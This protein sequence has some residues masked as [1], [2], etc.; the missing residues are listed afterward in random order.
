MT[1]EALDL[2]QRAQRA[3]QT[4]QAIALQDPDA[5]AS[6]SY[7]A[8]F[9][10][11]SALFALEGKTYSKHSGVEGAVH[12]DLVKAGRWS[13]DLGVDYSWLSNL[14]VTADYGGGLHVK[15]AEAQEAAVKASRLIQ[16]VQTASSEAF[17]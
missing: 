17:P 3:L 15:P 8:A 7:Y 6:R 2:W 12:R 10:A 13:A 16:A 4:A 9:Y 5:S 11:I 1:P 14:R